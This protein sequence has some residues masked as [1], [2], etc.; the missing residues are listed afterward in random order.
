MRAIRRFTVRTVLPEPL[1]PLGELVANLRW[2][3]HQPTQD[4]LA[5]VD[6]QVWEAVRHDPVHLLAEVGPGRLA[7]L[8]GDE[9]F[10]VRVRDL[11]AFVRLTDA[12]QA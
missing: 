5:A 12:T 8:A 3:W 4:L 1:A 10:L 6:P 7:E 9:A 2:S 11:A